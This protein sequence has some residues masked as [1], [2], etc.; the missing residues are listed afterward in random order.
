MQK[1]SILSLHLWYGG[2]EKSIAA[3]ANILCEKYQVEIACV[4]KLND[5]CVFDLDDRVNIKYL[6]P[7]SIVPNRDSFKEAVAVRNFYKIF[8]E[9]YTAS[10]VLY[11]R[12]KSMVN[13]IKN[14]DSD[15]I[16]STRDI[17][18]TWTGLY[19]K[20]GVVK[21]GW[22]H[23]HY[24]DNMKYANKVI[25]SAKKLDYFVLVSSSLRDFY[26]KKLDKCKC[27][28]IPNCIEYIPDKKSKLDKKRLISVGRLSPEKGYLDLLKVYNKVIIDY[29]DWNLDIIG[30]GVEKEKLEEYISKNSL[31]GVT[32][33]GFQGKDYI[34]KVMLDSSIYLMTSFTESFG[35]V[36]IE[37]MSYGLPCIAMNSA[38]GALDIIEDNY[39]G[40]LIDNRS[41][42]M[43][44]SK[45]GELIND[46][47]KRIELGDNALKS[48]S[49]YTSGIVGK[50]WYKLIEESGAN[51]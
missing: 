16:I 33:H 45:I 26:S 11:Y 23:N 47:E 5:K 19:A 51:E 38:E 31:T 27:V 46:K 48:V 28:Y 36:L 10:K 18:N 37:A 7:E 24:H 29:P 22:E 4:Y 13:Y 32:L 3:L 21:I 25:N 2:I 15:I 14:C 43:M 17:F 30:D 42:D 12:K 49:K 6:N 39:N 50:E 1:I 41:A 35:I 8:K 44:A 9:S 40:Y 34:E 20:P